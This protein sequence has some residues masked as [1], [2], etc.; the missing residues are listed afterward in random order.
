MLAFPSDDLNYLSDLNDL[1]PLDIE[2]AQGGR[3]M[4]LY[5]CHT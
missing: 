2:T 1:N 5:S 4:K 3:E